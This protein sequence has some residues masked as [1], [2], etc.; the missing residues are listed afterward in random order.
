MNFGASTK[1][2]KGPK[3]TNVQVAVRC[4]PLN[5]AEKASGQP[6]VVTCD[7]ENK[8][9]LISHGPSSKKIN[10]TYTFDRVFGAYSRQEE[11]FES[12]VRPIVDETLAG[13]NCTI[14]AYGQ[15]GTGKTHTMEGDIFSEENAGIYPRSVKMILEQLEASK[16]EFTVRVSFLELYNE[17]LQDLLDTT[18]NKKL[19]LCE[20]VKKGV[21]C[22]NLEEIAV[23][24]VPDILDILQKGVQQRQTAATLCNKN[25]S[26]SHSI[27]TMKIM[28][29]EC[30]I[31]GEE[32]VR[33]GQLNLVDLAGSECVGR[34]GAKD[35]RAR[36][37]GSINQS[38]LTLGRVITALVDHH[39]HVPYR[40]SKLTR[41]LQESLGGKA[42]TCIIATL[43]PC[44]PAIEETMSTLDYANR[45][46]N[47]KNK[48]TVNEKLTKKVVMKEYFAEIEVLKSQLMATR[49]KNGV[50]VDPETF[51]SMETRLAAQENQITECESALSL[52]IEEL[53]A[54]K[55]ERDDLIEDLSD[56]RREC[57]RVTEELA[58]ANETVTA[59]KGEFVDTF[60]ELRA[61]E[62][63]VSKQTA[64]EK[65]L[66]SAGCKMQR[67]LTARQQDISSLLSKI[68]R[69]S[70]KENERIDAATIFASSLQQGNSALK[71][72]LI[73]LSQTGREHS[74]QLSNGVSKVLQEGKE[75]CNVLKTSIDE[76]ISVLTGDAVK[77]RDSMTASCIGLKSHL[78]D[79]NT[80][81]QST[82]QSLQQQLSE[83][84]VEVDSTLQTAQQQLR[85]QQEQ[86]NTLTSTVNSRVESIETMTSQFLVSQDGLRKQCTAQTEE[87][88]AELVLKMNT[89]VTETQRAA[90]QQQ[91]ELRNKASA[92][93]EMFNTMMQQ[94]V[95]SAGEATQSSISRTNSLLQDTEHTVNTGA[96]KAIEFNTRMHSA[97]EQLAASSS[98][99]NESTKSELSSGMTEIESSRQTTF[100]VTRG[101]SERVGAKRKFLEETVEAL[102]SEVGTAIEEGCV[103]VDQTSEQANTILTEVNA[104]A[105]RM[106]ESATRHMDAFNVTLS[107]EGDSITAGL[108]T[109]FNALDEHIAEQHT[110][111]QQS[112]TSACEFSDTAV[113]SRLQ[114]LGSTPQK[115]KYAALPILEATSPHRNIK[116]KVAQAITGDAAQYCYDNVHSSVAPQ[117]AVMTASLQESVDSTAIATAAA[118]EQEGEED[119]G[120]M[121]VA[122]DEEDVEEINSMYAVPPP[123]AG[124]AEEDAAVDDEDT[125]SEESSVSSRNSSMSSRKSSKMALEIDAAAA[126]DENENNAINVQAPTPTGTGTTSKSS[127]SSKLARPTSARSKLQ[128]PVTVTSRRAGSRRNSGEVV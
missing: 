104:A 21:V 105:A 65:K 24:N 128:E 84:L 57:E 31:D 61:T 56:S 14:F 100:D 19:K 2:E 124:D 108:S 52:R 125:R 4:R 66:T 18:A 12:I 58:E 68:D 88:R 42:K 47:I 122:G 106:N 23:M 62:G 78:G 119:Q 28:I 22:Q 17:E 91:A 116:R 118:V 9:V 30:N 67:D 16:A 49:E 109:H 29:K 10:K 25:S 93:T 36:E 73:T 72:Q 20:D 101:I 76:A 90:N 8:Q 7:T 40:D 89:Y 112:S 110:G 64:T 48:P 126:N 45:A 99:I 55:G 38:L 74:V 120:T 13:F 87:L 59:V 95:T 111:L 102:Q 27:F 80:H 79:T 1:V 113:A 98:Q 94:M 83:W 44:A 71:A 6:T 107:K 53:K 127:R 63:V 75:T 43:S 35:D 54:V 32:V 103:V 115:T 33:H 60:V 81:L 121:I 77:A 117:L 92:L 97:C 50:Y 3:G 41:L 86:I 26:R 15:T 46:K 85:Q 11:V 51:Y 82:L 69:L 123:A 114:P 70:N 37:A 34:S 5:S 96:Q 39:G